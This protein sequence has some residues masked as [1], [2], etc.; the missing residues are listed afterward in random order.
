MNQ[1]IVRFVATTLG[2]IT[3]K[4]LGTNKW[5]LFYRQVSVTMCIKDDDGH[6]SMRSFSVA[7]TAK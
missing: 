4:A 2:R 7:Q 6:D 3:E 5:S 1:N